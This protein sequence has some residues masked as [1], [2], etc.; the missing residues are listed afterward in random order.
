ML[1][2]FWFLGTAAMIFLLALALSARRVAVAQEA[3]AEALGTLADAKLSEVQ[4]AAARVLEA[5]T[6][7]APA[8]SRSMLPG[9]TEDE[10]ARRLWRVR[11]FQCGTPIALCSCNRET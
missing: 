4:Q 7:P 3:Q 6:E 2:A 10:W 1:T 9:E 8:E 5:T 11:C